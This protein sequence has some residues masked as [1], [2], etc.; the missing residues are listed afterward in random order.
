[1]L[2]SP[3]GSRVLRTVPVDK[4]D[5]T[6]RSRQSPAKGDKHMNEGEGVNL[7]RLD[8]AVARSAA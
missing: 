5:R 4:P 1:M 7:A 8:S 3:Q 6:G 2:R